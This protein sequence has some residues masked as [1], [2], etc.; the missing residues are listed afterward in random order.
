MS[1]A[2]SMLL[3]LSHLLFF[4]IPKEVSQPDKDFDHIEEDYH[5][6]KL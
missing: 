6:E 3:E 2:M 5:H 1:T 4:F